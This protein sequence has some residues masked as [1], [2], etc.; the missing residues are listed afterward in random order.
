MNHRYLTLCLY[1]MLLVPISQQVI[2]FTV[3]YPRAYFIPS[4][5]RSYGGLEYKHYQFILYT[6]ILVEIGINVY[7]YGGGL[8]HR[9]MDITE[10]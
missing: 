3:V 2:I 7:H 5:T 6:T 1:L 9:N 8:L 10:I 4:A